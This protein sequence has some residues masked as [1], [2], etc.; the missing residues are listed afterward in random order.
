DAFIQIDDFVNEG[1]VASGSLPFQANL[2]IAGGA[3]VASVVPSEGA[4]WWADSTMMHV[5]APHPNCAYMWLEHSLNTQFQGDLPAGFG[6]VP[7]VPAACE[8]NELRGPDGCATNGFEDFED[9]WFWRTPVADCGD[10]RE[11]VPYYEWTTN[12]IAV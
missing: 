7:V 8:G 11:C 2:L 9:I 1:V 10:G 3:P 4:T 12:Y 5:N 6:S